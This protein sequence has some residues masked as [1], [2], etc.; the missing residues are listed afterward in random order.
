MYSVGAIA[1][2]KKN[3]GDRCFMAQAIAP[4]QASPIHVI[5]GGAIAIRT[6][7]D[8]CFF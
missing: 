3:S 1:F 2:G 6:V 8:H 7:G 4:V 5:V